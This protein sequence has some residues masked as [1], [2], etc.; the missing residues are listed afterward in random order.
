YRCRRTADLHSFPT[1]RSSDL[2]G[3]TAMLLW[4]SNTTIWLF[5][6]RDIVI[7]LTVIL[8]SLFITHGFYNRLIC[9][10][11]GLCIGELVFKIILYLDRKST[12]LNSSHVSISYAVF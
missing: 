11:F 7:P 12:R 3:Y 4:E 2:T 1:R 5:A 10:L 8:I 9:G 6:S